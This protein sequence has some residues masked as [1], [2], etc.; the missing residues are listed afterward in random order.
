MFFSAI[1]G[2]YAPEI[3]GGYGYRQDGMAPDRPSGSVIRD[4]Q[5]GLGSYTT[6]DVL[7]HNAKHRRLYENSLAKTMPV[8]LE[9]LATI[10]DPPVVYARQAGRNRSTIVR[11]PH[12]HGKIKLSKPNY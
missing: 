12:V 11:K 10:K 4:S 6:N 9:T 1:I 7:D 2:E 8:T 5:V 3:S